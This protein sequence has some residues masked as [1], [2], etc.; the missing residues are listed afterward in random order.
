MHEAATLDTWCPVIRT[1]SNALDVVLCCSWTKLS[2]T[3]RAK[4][5][6]WRVWMRTRL[7]ILKRRGNKPMGTRSV[8]GD[9]TSIYESAHTFLDRPQT[10]EATSQHRSLRYL[11]PS[12][13]RPGRDQPRVYQM[14]RHCR[15]DR[16]RQTTYQDVRGRP[17]TI[18]GRCA[19]G[20][21]Q[22]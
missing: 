10:K 19:G 11:D 7:P 9:F 20:V 22:A 3:N 4:Y 12:R 16:L 2:W 21:L 13:C 17:G 5:T 6:G 15:R 18:Q 14:W 1:D 8:Q